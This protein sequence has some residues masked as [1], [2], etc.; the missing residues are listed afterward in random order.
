MSISVNSIYRHPV[1]GLTPEL[2]DSVD[3]L[4]GEAIANDRRFALAL[5]STPLNTAATE[6]MS[7]SHFLMLQ[8]N[9]RLAQLETRFDDATDTLSVLRQGRKV[10]SGKLTE[11]IG[12][13]TI[14]EFFSAF[15]NEEARGRPKVVEAAGGHV[16]SDHD[17]PVISIINL[18]SVKDLERV[19]RTTVHP[20]RFRA[21]FWLEGT[22]PWHEFEWIG[23]QITIGD[24]RLTVTERINR[25]AAINVDPETAER[26]Q[27][28]IKALQMGFRHVDFGVYARVETAGSVA[29]GDRLSAPD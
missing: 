18:A 2:L 12:R 1:K 17:A 23:K 8:R 19:T 20:L 25:C 5:G 3:L 11:G 29:V 22:A 28:I 7:K 13:T 27:N 15:M 10:A 14:E 6:W 4:P 9:E 26:D 21:N 16:L 24:A